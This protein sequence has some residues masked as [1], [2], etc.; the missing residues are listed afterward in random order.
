MGG[1]ENCPKMEFNP[2]PLE[3]GTGEHWECQGSS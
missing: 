2:S 3:L 1:E